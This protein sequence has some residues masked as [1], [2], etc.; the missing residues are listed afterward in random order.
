MKILILRNSESAPEGAFGAWLAARGHDLAVVGGEAADAADFDRAEV[1]VSFGSPRGAYETDIPWIARQRTL[2]AQRMAQRLPTIGICFGA[3]MMAVAAGGNSERMADGRFFRGWFG[4]EHAADPVLAGP[5]PRWHGDAITAPPGAQVLA[6]D[7]G[8]VQAFAMPRAIGVQFH[9]EA[10]PKIMQDWA[11]R[12][13]KPGLVDAA[14]LAAESARI[15][16]AREEARAALYA[17]M[18]RRATEG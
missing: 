3:Q 5:W 14:A 11:E 9:P 1:V 7:Q 16:P 10:T 13:T 17:W 8:T 12:F 6:T 15:Y 4:I 18:L 2:L